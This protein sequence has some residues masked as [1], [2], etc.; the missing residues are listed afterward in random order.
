[1]G[2]LL[3]S[4]YSTTNKLHNHERGQGAGLIYENL[5]ACEH[6]SGDIESNA[7]ALWQIIVR[8]L[9]SVDFTLTDKIGWTR[10]FLINGARIRKDLGI[11]FQDG[12]SGCT[13]SGG[14]WS[15]DIGSEA[16]SFIARIKSGSTYLENINFDDS[17]SYYGQNDTFQPDIPLEFRASEWLDKERAKY[18]TVLSQP[19]D[20]TDGNAYP[21]ANLPHGA[22]ITQVDYMAD[23][24]NIPTAAGSFEIDLGLNANIAAFYLDDVVTV[25]TGGFADVASAPYGLYGSKTSG[26]TESTTG[27]VVRARIDT[28]SAG[29][30]KIILR[31][32]YKIKL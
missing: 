26:I 28:N 30:G 18:F 8:G 19:L 23:N 14:H 27:G 7:N 21:V 11:E 22:I 12:V 13:V 2:V 25:P 10:G 15:Q 4:S 9:P 17:N 32:W 6:T 5:Q 20:I 31:I 24:S 16:N 29:T 3:T 1:M